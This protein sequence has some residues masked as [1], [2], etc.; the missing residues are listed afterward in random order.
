MLTSLNYD[1]GQGLL[2]RLRNAAGEFFN[3]TTE[4]FVGA[5]SADCL[6]ELS[7]FENGDGMSLYIASVALPDGYPY[8]QELILPSGEVIASGE[9]TD[10]ATAVAVGA[11]QA[12]SD[13]LSTLV[14]GSNPPIT[15]GELIDRLYIPAYAGAVVTVPASVDPATQNVHFFATRGDKTVP[16]GRTLTARP[17]EGQTTD[18]SL[19]DK[20]VLTA[21]LDANGYAFLVLLRGVEYSVH[22][23]WW[24]AEFT[25]TVTD[26]DS[27]MAVNYIASSVDAV[28]TNMGLGVANSVRAQDG[29]VW[30]IM[31]VDNGDGTF[32][33]PM[34]RIA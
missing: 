16:A 18:Y 7:E 6:V 31:V 11:I 20:Q 23:P 24:G 3:F 21:T 17:T 25:F 27:Q 22:A 13:P 28:I 10:N 8:I 15:R 33:T 29:T 32:S 4:L 26:E 2:L 14:P 1:S 5:D 34:V 30:Q 19:V 9:A 12:V